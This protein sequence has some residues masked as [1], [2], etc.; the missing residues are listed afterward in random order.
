MPTR[1][2]LLFTSNG[3]QTVMLMNQTRETN[4]GANTI[5]CGN[6]QVWWMPCWCADLANC[7]THHNHKRV[8][9]MLFLLYSFV[10]ICIIV[11]ALQ[12][13]V[14]LY[15]PFLWPK[16]ETRRSPC[17]W[18]KESGEKVWKYWNYWEKSLQE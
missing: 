18:I 16:Q 7:E 8:A 15:L 6:N 4:V 17:N 3:V 5:Y 13:S 14:E 9:G 12:D 1:S 10:T 11:F 2:A